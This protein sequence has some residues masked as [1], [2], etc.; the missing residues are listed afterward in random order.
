MRILIDH[1]A[2]E[3]H[4]DLAMLE[5][6]VAQLGRLKD[7]EISVQAS[8]INWPLPDIRVI[9][10]HLPPPGASVNRVTKS[11]RIPE[12]S[13]RMLWG[14]ADAW[15]KIVY[16]RVA[17]G[18]PVA[19]CRIHTPSG[20]Q[21]LGQWVE[22]FDALF[23]A[24]GGD[25]NDVFPQALW[26]CCALV[27]AFAEQGKPILLSGQQL[28]P[29]QRSS[30]V[31]L[32]HSTLRQAGFVG[33]R[34]PTTSLQICREAGVRSECMA[35]SGDDS[36]GLAPGAESDVDKVL[37]DAG[38]EPG[39]FI[40][41][42]L[43]IAPYCPVGAGQLKD[44]A[45]L[46]DG[47][48]RRHGRPLLAVPISYGEGDSDLVTA[49]WLAELLK[50]GR[51]HILDSSSMSSALVK[52]V[53]ARAW[54][55]IGS[56]YHFCTFALSGGVPAIALYEGAYYRQKALGTAAFWGDARLALSLGELQGGSAADRITAVLEDEALRRSLRQRAEESARAWE[57]S[58]R[59]GVRRAFGLQMQADPGSPVACLVP[60][61]E[62]HAR[63]PG[64]TA[65]TS[66]SCDPPGPTDAHA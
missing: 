7:V 62:P 28:G 57:V 34:E 65:A 31:V 26:R 52:G 3:N 38:V 48:A 63:S 47:L 15:R 13:R 66:G 17:S 21:R 29:V 49:V 64:S 44:V 36:L 18:A 53:L 24:G 45:G 54:G 2:Y 58:F 8:P 46:L 32:L 20:E 12:I 22:Q 9:E 61:H 30:S 42:N 33:L 39:D 55:A 35:M 41:V 43:R 50:P 16:R 40:A 25:L 56:S 1:G 60:R 59:E 19:A 11:K 4:G 37:R 14:A 10:Y 27:H 5:A 6:A 51:L 23:V